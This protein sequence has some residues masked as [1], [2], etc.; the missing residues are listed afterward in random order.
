V[1]C[2][3]RHHHWHPCRRTLFVG[4]AVRSAQN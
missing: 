2:P 4:A 1:P 3:G